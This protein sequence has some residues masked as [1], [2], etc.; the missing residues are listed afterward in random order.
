MTG[1]IDK[2][3]WWLVRS[4][5]NRHKIIVND[6]EEYLLRFYIKH[7]GVL[8]GLYLHKFF[9]GDKDRNLHNHPWRWSFSLILTGGYDEERLKGNTILTRR[10]GPGRINLLAGDTFHRISLVDEGYGAWT[11][12][13]SGEKV[14]GW[15]FLVEETGE[16]IPQE[17][18]LANR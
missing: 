1:L 8:P 7:N 6:G 11:M 18:Y 10:M 2:L 3:C 15:G 16:V 4:F 9:R 12:F 13:C 17:E 5:P 14:K